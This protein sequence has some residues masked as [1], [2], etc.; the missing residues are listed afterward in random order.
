MSVVCSNALSRAL[1]SKEKSRILSSLSPKRYSLRPSS[2]D[3]C[4]D[5]RCS[6]KSFLSWTSLLAWFWINS[7]EKFSN[8]YVSI[9]SL[10]S[11]Q[12]LEIWSLTLSFKISAFAVVS[13]RLLKTYSPRKFFNYILSYYFYYSEISSF[14][15]DGYQLSWGCTLTYYL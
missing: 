10:S 1:F 7:S 5:D 2:N 14:F 3:P 9:C 12:K 15:K 11:A 6:S 4:N 8:K 13:I